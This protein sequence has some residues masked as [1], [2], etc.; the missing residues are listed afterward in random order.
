MGP[1]G[2]A[3]FLLTLKRKKRGGN[4]ADRDRHRGLTSRDND[5]G[6]GRESVEVG[7]LNLPPIPPHSPHSLS[8]QRKGITY[9]KQRN[10]GGRE[11]MESFC[12]RLRI[13][14]KPSKP[15]YHHR[16]HANQKK[17]ERRCGK[18][19]TQQQI[20]DAYCLRGGS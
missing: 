14:S 13:K 9:R 3:H 16:C 15:L 4:L 10:K 19:R 20:N 11:R 6:E 18:K 7:R 12:V 17:K 5:M 1:L 8:P 2:H